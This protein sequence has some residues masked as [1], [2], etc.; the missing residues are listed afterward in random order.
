MLSVVSAVK[1]S[2]I[3]VFTKHPQPDA[4]STQGLEHKRIILSN[5]KPQLLN[6]LESKGCRIKHK[7]KGAT[8][9]D[10]PKNVRVNAREARVFHIIDLKTDGFIKADKLWSMG[11]TGRGINIVVLDTGVDASHEELR[12]SIAGQWDFVNNDPI[13]EDGHGHG[14]MITGIITGAGLNRVKNN[15]AKGVAPNSRV[16]MLKVCNSQGACYEDDILAALE[17]AKNLNAKIVSISLGGGSFAGHCDFDPVASKVN[18]LA[19]QGILVVV[20]AGNRGS[21]VSSPACASKAL[22]VGAVDN[23]GY[24][25]WW[26]NHGY[27]LDILAPGVGV[28]ST[29]SCLAAGDCNYAWYAH[30]DGT[31]ASAPH[32]AGV[33]ALLLQAKPTASAKA[34]RDAILNTAKNPAGCYRCS[35]IRYGKCYGKYR[36]YCRKTEKGA[37]IIDAY[38]AYLKLTGGKSSAD[39][40]RDGIPDSQDACPQEYGKDCNGCPNPC[41]GC[42]VMACVPGK[43]PSCVAGACPPTECPSDGCGKDRCQANQWADYPSFVPNTCRVYGNTG[44]CTHNS[45]YGKA[46][47]SYSSKCQAGDY[48]GD[49]PGA[50]CWSGSNEY[51]K[52]SSSHLRK[53][54]KCAAGVY[55]Y[56]SYKA[57]RSITTVYKYLDYRNNNNW[58]T[59]PTR[60]YYAVY[61][62]KCADGKWYQTDTDYYN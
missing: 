2:N 35:Y 16:Y 21:G 51:I 47:C 23:N 5:P 42:A 20:A 11:I 15:Y 46:T 22:A 28:L 59:K 61:A 25:P 18:W 48:S 33:A 37:G 17:Y 52:R 4:I 13:A 26:S 50:K 10:C 1:I 34:I 7:L 60:T 24:V 3:R 36:S 55:S 40:D 45:C 62:V 38:S 56:K 41:S 49:E 19:D 8:S 53:F 12:N 43:K 58:R 32:V 6:S 9:F 44:Y 27:A 39:S 31:S 57:K 14:T 29:M 54:C 30:I